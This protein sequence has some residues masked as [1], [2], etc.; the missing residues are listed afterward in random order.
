MAAAFDAV[1]TQT[2]THA[3]FNHTPVGTPTLAVL[4]AHLD[5][6][7]DSEITGVT[8]GG[9]AMTRKAWIDHQ[10]VASPGSSNAHSVEV[11]VKENPA[12]GVQSVAIT[13]T[14]T[15]PVD[16]VYALST[17]TG[18]G[19]VG[20]A[21]TTSDNA[22]TATT[23]SIAG[24]SSETNGIVIDALTTQ[25]TEDHTADGGQTERWDLSDGTGN[26]ACGSTEPGAASVT[27]GW[28]WTT[29]TRYAYAAIPVAP[30]AASSVTVPVGALVFTGK[31][32]IA[33][34][35]T[36]PVPP[37]APT[38]CAAVAVGDTITMTWTDNSAGAA[39]HRVYIRRTVDSQWNLDGETELAEVSYTFNWLAQSVAY[40][41]GVT[42]FDADAESEMD[43]SSTTPEATQLVRRVSG[44]FL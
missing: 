42:S 16:E 8:Y 39:Q 33:A 9:A 26:R 11:W 13:T 25:E 41:V 30:A 22:N 7:T 4:T 40:T 37:A 34:S 17:Y 29:I 28:S 6:D 18:T 3:S 27:V 38:D 21:S 10:G 44:S 5:N 1:T 31:I 36:V 14:G 2:G 15:S 24:V 19:A 43:T 20:T 12:T 23:A 35:G 32:P